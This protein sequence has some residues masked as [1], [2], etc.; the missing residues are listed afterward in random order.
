MPNSCDRKI[1][2]F[3]ELFA[4]VNFSKEK[5][6]LF[7]GINSRIYILKLQLFS[8]IYSSA[9]L[10]FSLTSAPSMYNVEEFLH[11]SLKP[12][13]FYLFIWIYIETT[14][15]DYRSVSSTMH[16]YAHI[17]HPPSYCTSRYRSLIT[18]LSHLGYIP[19]PGTT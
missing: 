17:L 13:S 3:S 14:I 12:L 15:S 7:F 6:S 19:E 8:I 4:S 5:P 16:P 11:F 18:T 1:F 10:I 9:F 2:N